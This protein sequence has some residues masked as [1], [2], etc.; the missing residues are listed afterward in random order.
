MK[1]RIISLMGFLLVV[2]SIVLLG[3]F[4]NVKAEGTRCITY[5][6]YYFFVVI[7]NRSVY[8][9]AVGLDTSTEDYLTQQADEGAVSAD[10][11]NQQTS[12]VNL[13]P[14]G[15]QNLTQANIPLNRDT[16]VDTCNTSSCKLFS[17]YNY[18][19]IAA[20]YLNS[21]QNFFGTY[22]PSTIGGYC[23]ITQP[24]H[25]IRYIA[26][27]DWSNVGEAPSTD[28][29]NFYVS[30]SETTNSP[31][32]LANGSI[33][34]TINNITIPDYENATVLRTITGAQYNGIVADFTTV[35][36]N[37]NDENRAVLLPTLYYIQYDL[38]E[39]VYDLVVKYQD[40][41][42]NELS[43][44]VGP[45]EYSIGASYTTETKDIN[46]YIYLRTIDNISTDGNESTTQ[47]MSGN[48]P[49]HDVEII[50]VYEPTNPQTGDYLIYIAWAIGV[51]SLGYAI[52]YYVSHY[53]KS[54]I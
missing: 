43:T 8:A 14:V 2:I 28:V 47:D 51:L 22:V 53:K 7:N 3:S 32:V 45:T 13:V 40:E 25:V 36:N 1:K 42:G 33:L 39:T 9:E 31:E 4:T 19:K 38:C 12:F 23:E 17:F 20:N 5:T 21:C 54:E 41:E 10:E 6:N 50:Y 24:S 48:M 35:L 52:Y 16:G 46:D 34:A 29:V 44:Q 49:S 11:F 37:G 15:A 18:Y 26:H 27:D 30:A